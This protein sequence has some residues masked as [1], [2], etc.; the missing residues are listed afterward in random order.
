MT[1][2]NKFYFDFYFQ[3]RFFRRFVSYKSALKF[4][5]STNQN[6]VLKKVKKRKLSTREK[7]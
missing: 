5:T 4:A 7:E 2:K 6:W 3:N 1:T